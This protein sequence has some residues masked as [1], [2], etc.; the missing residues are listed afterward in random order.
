MDATEVLRALESALRARGAIVR[1]GGDYDDWD[2]EVRGS[3]FG[4]V[5]VCTVAEN[6]GPGKHML[7]V[8]SRLWFSIHALGTTLLFM[9]PSVGAAIDRATR[10]A[11]ILGALGAVFGALTLRSGAVAV[12]AIHCALIELGFKR[13]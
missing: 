10:P 12:S 9:L 13:P 7:R 2:L 5:R 4:G 11:A 1:R 8:R 3:L 6:Y